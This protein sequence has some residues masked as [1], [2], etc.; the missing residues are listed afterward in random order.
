[1]LLARHGQTA[2]NAAARILG[3]RDPPLS[4]QGRADAA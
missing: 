3:R 2:D 4:G 1:M